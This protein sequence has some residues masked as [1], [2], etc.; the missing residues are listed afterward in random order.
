[1]SLDPT[2]VNPPAVVEQPPAADAPVVAE[3]APVA[4]P[5]EPF[6]GPSFDDLKAKHPESA[7]DLTRLDASHRELHKR[8]LAEAKA[9][10]ERLQGE[11][12]RLKGATPVASPLDMATLKRM[13]AGE[14]VVDGVAPAPRPDF[15]AVVEEKIKAKGDAVLTDTSALAEILSET[16]A[17]AYE[18]ATA[19][20]VDFYTRR[21]K[22]AVKK[23]YEPVVQAHEASEREAA[24]Q[25][26]VAEV[27]Q[28]PGMNDDAAFDTVYDAMEKAGREGVDGF[29]LTYAEM[30][31]KNPGWTKPPAPKEPEVVVR[32][33]QP[34]PVAAPKAEPKAPTMMEMAEMLSA[35]ASTGSRAA[36][37]APGATI[38]NRPSKVE[39][40]MMDP[41]YVAEVTADDG[42][43]AW[44]RARDAQRKRGILGA[45]P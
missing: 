18:K 10:E 2:P 15:R 44:E 45:R 25:R 3:P 32:P 11:V 14:D 8:A 24:V 31:S 16:I 35:T 12:E 6:K 40:L 41:S 36:T 43:A 38:G 26:A 19:D 9:R 37:R 42:R 22:A 27:R 29:R 20:A 17:A 5:Q 7:E 30:L 1:M 28:L 34:P 39:E 33:T 21:E 13:V 4:A 23:L